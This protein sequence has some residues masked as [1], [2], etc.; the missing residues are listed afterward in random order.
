MTFQAR[1]V[2]LAVAA[3]PVFIFGLLFAITP[4]LMAQVRSATIT[5][6]VTDPTGAV[7]PGADVIVIAT[8]TSV[9][10]PTKSDKL[11]LYTVP[12]LAAGDYTIT[13]AKGGFEKFTLNDLHLASAQSV[14]EDVKLTVGAETVSVEVT[15][16]AQLL[17]T[18]DGTLSGLTPAAVIDVIPNVTNNPFLYVTLQ[19]GVFGNPSTTAFSIGTGGRSTMTSF[20]VNG[21]QSQENQVMIDGL[22]VVAGGN[23]DAAIIPNL[24]GISSVQVLTNAYSS[25]YGRG[26][27]QFSITSKSGTNKFHG[28][29]DYEI[30]NEALMAN[31]AS[32]KVLISEAPVSATTRSENVL[33]V[34]RAAKPSK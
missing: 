32:N 16:G 31:T 29:A 7:I 8:A 6:L 10:Y 17:D 1:S 22:P 26:A 28:V 30:R 24:E 19:N 34:P 4:T 21:A 15:A 2:R 25:E 9:S 23:N 33:R 11:G 18:E 5:G 13:I 3:I 14:R 12:Y 20:S 27:G